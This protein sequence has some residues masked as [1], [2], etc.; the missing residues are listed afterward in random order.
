M[1]RLSEAIAFVA[2]AFEGQKRKC[3]DIPAVFHSLEAGCI[4]QTLT[5]D[6]D[7]VIATLL[8]DTVEDADVTLVEIAA[9][10][11]PRVAE[12]VRGETEDKRPTESPEATWQLR[13]QEAVETLRRTQD[14]S[15]KILFLSDKLSNMRSLARAHERQ[16]DAMWE[17]FHQKDPAAHARYYRAIADALSELAETA[18][19]RE[20][21]ALIE[22]TFE[23]VS[24]GYC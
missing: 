4:A 7:T 17:A 8:H 11:G 9:R 24:Y 15:L 14:V 10:F 22:K 20:Y 23:G 18:A 6:E 12:L 2:V 21:T 3:E 16:G 19:Y 1:E 5:T 13:K